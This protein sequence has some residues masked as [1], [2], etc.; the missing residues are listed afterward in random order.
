MKCY[1]HPD[2]EAIA[3]C[4]DC[5]KGLCQECATRWDPPICDSCQNRRGNA[6]LASLNREV[7]LYA[8]LSIVGIVFGFVM[9]SSMKELGA[10]VIVL[11]F[12]YGITFPMYAAGWKWLNHLTDRFTLLATPM[13]WIIYLFVKLMLSAVVGMIALPYRLYSIFKRKSE[14]HSILTDK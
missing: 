5:G 10:G 2:Q 14:I 12:T 8:G 3:Q 11:I 9:A 4:I 13:V 1:N 7:M 6:E